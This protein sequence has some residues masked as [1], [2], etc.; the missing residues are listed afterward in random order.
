MQ[1]WEH[2]ITVV[3]GKRQLRGGDGGS[4]GL[5]EWLD[6]GVLQQMWW[7]NSQAQGQEEASLGWAL[8]SPC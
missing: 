4:G 1:H 7:E 6:Q 2:T 8:L 5:D 3:Q